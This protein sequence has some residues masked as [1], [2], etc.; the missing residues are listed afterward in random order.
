MKNSNILDSINWETLR[1]EGL[2]HL[3]AM[4]GHL[5]TDYD[6]HDPGVTIFEILCYAIADLHSRLSQDTI[7]LL[8][9]N[10]KEKQFFSPREILTMN[11]VTMNDYR[12]LL[13]DIPGVK[14]AWLFPAID[15]DPTLYYDKDNN[16][17]LYD[18]ASGS[19]RI[20]LKG[21]Y[22]VY[23]EKDGDY[24]EKDETTNEYH[25]LD[26]IE[27]KR[28]VEAKLH[29]YRNLGEE[30]AEINIMA[31]ET[32][33][34]FSD[35][36]IAETADANEVIAKIYYDLKNFISPR[37][38]Q[39]SLKRMFQKGKSIEQIFNGPQLENGFID[40]DEL[41]S[42]EK[43]KELHTSD[44]IRIIMSHPEVRD[45]RNLFIANVPNPDMNDKK[46]W[47]L[48]VDDTKALVMEPFNSVRIRLFKKEAM[49]PVITT[50]VNNKVMEL[51]EQSKWE[52]FDD[53]AVD[54][55]ETLGEASDVT[56]YKPLTYQFP[57]TYGVGETGLSSA[58]T[59]KRRA[60]AQQLKAYLLFFDQIL[61]NYLR[62]LDSFKQIFAFRQSPLFYPIQVEFSEK[63]NSIL[64]QY[65][66]V[67][68]P[69]AVDAFI[70]IGGVNQDLSQAIWT[71][72][73]TEGLIDANGNVLNLLTGKTEDFITSIIETAVIN[74]IGGVDRVYPGLFTGIS[75]INDALSNEIWTHLR[76]M[77]FINNNGEILPAYCPD[78]D[79]FNLEMFS[80]NN[81]KTY[82]SQLPP[83]EI[84][85]AEFPEITINYQYLEGDPDDG[86][87]SGEKT[88]QREN[89][90]L[91]HL[92]AQ[93]NEK[94]ADY[95]LFGFKNSSYL[96]AKAGFLRNYPELSRNRNRACNILA[97]IPNGQI[98]QY[99]DGLKDLIAAKLGMAISNTDPESKTEYNNFFIV[100]H[101]LFR[102]EGS[103][104][105]NFICSEKVIESYQPDPYSYRLTFVFSKNVGRFSNSKFK[106]LV[107]TTIENETPAHISYAILELDSIKMKLFT[108]T[109]RDFLRELKECKTSN[110]VRNN[111][112]RNKLIEF[113][114]I[115]RVKLP[116][117]HL[118]AH[119]M[120]GNGTDPENE[121]VVTFWKD[122]SRNDHDVMLETGDSLL[123]SDD[124][125]PKYIKT[126]TGNSPFVRFS[127]GIRL[128]AANL[129]IR[130]D[131]SMIVVYKA[132]AN[133]GH[134]D[135]YFK[136]LT[137][138][139]SAKDNYI[140]AVRGDGAVTGC[141]HWT[142]D[143]IIPASR[144]KNGDYLLTGGSDSN[145][146][147]VA[148]P[149]E[150]SINGTTAFVAEA[151]ASGEAANGIKVTVTDASDHI[152]YHFD[153]LVAG[154]EI[155]RYENLSMSRRDIN[156]NGDKYIGTQN[157]SNISI[158][159]ILT[160]YN[161]LLNLES[162]TGA[163]HIAIL[164]REKATGEFKIS[165]DGVLQTSQQLPNSNLPFSQSSLFIGPANDNGI[166]DLGEVIILDSVLNGNQKQK[167]EEYLSEKWNIPLSAVN[168]ISKPVL[169]LDASASRSVICNEKTKQIIM[170][171]DLSPAGMD[172]APQTVGE[173]PEYHMEGIG[174]LPAVYFGNPSIARGCE[175]I[176]PNLDDNKLFAGD[177]T[178]AI[179]YQ[180]DDSSVKG[181][182]RLLDGTATEA[183]P[184]K[185]SCSIGVDTYNHLIVR[186]GSETVKLAA[187]LNDP[188]I[189]IITGEVHHIQLKVSL[190]LDGKVSVAGEFSDAQVFKNCPN[191][192]AIGRSRNGENSFAGQ[193][194]QIIIYNQALTVWNR[195][196]LENYLSQ[197]WA[198]DISG[199]DRIDIPVLHLD[200]SRRATVMDDDNLKVSQWLDLSCFGNHANQNSFSRRPKFSANG[201]N[202]LGSIQL[203]QTATDGTDFYEDSLTI[204]RIIQ[205]DFTI[206]V[207]F[208]PDFGY[209]SGEGSG[210]ITEV[211]EET[212]WTKGVAILD[213]DCSGVYNDFGLS[214]GK[215]NSKMIVM[216]GIG[217]RLTMD[218]TIKTGELEFNKPHFVT[219]TRC[220][221]TGEVKLY[222]DGMLHAEAD[223][224][225]NVILNDSRSIKI[226]AFNSEGSP[227]HGFIGEVIIFDTMLTDKKRQ[228]IE[229]YLSAKWG[230]PFV[231]LPIDTT[232]LGLHLDAAN[233]ESIVKEPNNAVTRWIFTDTV[234]DIAATQD[235]SANRP[236][237]VEESFNGMPGVRF[238]N[239]FMI[240]EPDI[241][242]YD[243]LT[244]ALIFNPLS[245]G[246]IYPGWQYGAGLID[247]DTGGMAQNFGIAVNRNKELMMRIGTHQIPSP[248]TLNHPHIVVITREKQNG[249][250][251][252]R[253]Y[254]DG[255]SAARKT[256]SGNQSLNDTLELTI[257]AI[258]MQPGQKVSKGYFHGDIS[259]LI[260]FNRVLTIAERQILEKHLAMKWRIDTSG[261]NEISKPVLHL[262]ASLIGTI[263][264]T[265]SD[266]KISQ[267]LDVNRHYNNAVQAEQAQRP[268]YVT[269]PEEYN[270]L[271]VI[272]FDSKQHQCLTLKPVVKDDFTVI[273]VYKAADSNET[274][275]YMPVARDSFA[276]L[277]GNNTDQSEAVWLHLKN[278]GY[279]DGEGNVLATFAPGKTGFTLN[280]DTAV[281]NP[282][283]GKLESQ[284]SSIL[285]GYYDSHTT[286]ETDTFAEIGGLNQTLSET[287]RTRLLEKG[288]INERGAV[289]KAFT[290]NTESFIIPV[291]KKAIINEITRILV[292]PVSTSLFT[293]ISGINGVLSNEI[294]NNLKNKGYIDDVGRVL[295][296]FT[297]DTA[298]FT[299][300]LDPSI[301]GVIQ[302]EFIDKISSIVSMYY[303]SYTP[304]PN[305]AFTVIEGVSQAL[306]ETIKANMLEQGYIDILGYILKD[307]TDVPEAFF[308]PIIEAAIIN[309]II[310]V[311]R[312][313]RDSFTGVYGVNNTLSSAI[314]GELNNLGYFDDA[315]KVSPEITPDGDDFTLGLDITNPIQGKI[316]NRIGSILSGC[317]DSEIT[318]PVDAFTVIDGFNQ[319]LSQTVLAN[320]KE[321]GFITGNGDVRKT[322]TQNTEDFIIPIIET[323]II[324]IILAE[325]WVAGAGLF[326]GN[327]AGVREDM[328]KRD[329]G[330][331]IGRTGTFIVGIGVPGENDS[332]IEM[333]APFEAVHIGV[334]TRKKDTGMV[335]LF[336][337][338][339]AS[340]PVRMARNVI[341]KDSDRF[342]IGAVNTAGNYFKGDIAE[343]IVL[344][345]VLEPD[346][347]TAIQR[348]L[349]RKWG[350]PGIGE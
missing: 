218:H 79:G 173:G 47:A 204:S 240:V 161:E 91:N 187:T 159:D 31:Q 278:K 115:G 178:I 330:I 76:N 89:R 273:I 346:E 216:G 206:M 155:V 122:L 220:K 20:A 85:Q 34:V 198:I 287:I 229:K 219:F 78:Q 130:E 97:P 143:N 320:L 348:F 311:N 45:V 179:V 202:G 205:N 255:L 69:V 121:A 87:P 106:E 167:L 93:F 337:D 1:E 193:I 153:L 325:N 148:I 16:A 303:D 90:I 141:I 248:I 232:D 59:A 289:L 259:E 310:G 118:D 43:R 297:P 291:I 114:G 197:K 119:N 290:K 180:A 343:I 101:I 82:F 138:G 4:T 254:V 191:D 23:I 251:T 182:G 222:A 144:P 36:E 151:L 166:C 165:L 267:W 142:A 110:L 253:M 71:S 63:I 158:K 199:V 73:R 235:N 162:T 134:E 28:R 84:W 21:L 280:L 336:I 262:D 105:L 270:G 131:F 272:R 312:I 50:K 18:Y 239:S 57:S 14:N 264:K 188:H 241:N 103:L 308:N 98:F 72:L 225:D 329:F 81:I 174:G 13:I 305:D 210:I 230:I 133:P 275:A 263:V 67:Q 22:R 224:R 152:E 48:V 32:I 100:D 132:T 245:T 168:S 276:S 238:N 318:V 25:T 102:P 246:N 175:L 120:D 302:E 160:K 176:I 74:A 157:F 208:Q 12:K 39:Y 304:I 298:G 231:T 170:W 56:A 242:G 140:L 185:T 33:S 344:N 7:N 349:A 38:K 319:E 301:M 292:T 5:W 42:G 288:F 274:S 324:N 338:N 49:S 256:F 147:N 37:V 177:F 234:R 111:P 284:I 2:K 146:A 214:F 328:Y 108:D 233:F 306:S 26:D 313:S 41:G 35:I 223:L 186:G 68:Q 327:C 95:A 321:L 295:P 215:S 217:D 333:A 250:E 169:Q 277:T 88:F 128:K 96:N 293:G 150:D 340:E 314:W 99:T 332:K 285:S 317:V 269:T 236:Y 283:Q 129:P 9:D 77:R 44:L 19:Q 117:L 15:A 261:I 145:K 294:W 184:G 83:A 3:Q 61:V 181:E 24:T 94:F 268:L 347:I 307:F 55:E 149:L 309:M 51:Q 17:L 315:G 112:Y 172:A 46:E 196:R 195:Q 211:L 286:V 345:E 53:P 6:I 281:C 279:I 339:E 221:A 139:D 52:I 107:Y 257:G 192:L 92:L 316:E 183:G 296:A 163:S 125:K 64:S 70:S 66:V 207:A 203:T 40:D 331:L 104:P 265:E 190:Y 116:I 249:T 109:Y 124:S 228:S 266:N 260:L 300:D 326:D 10:T 164:T 271:G 86:T 75:G 212:N 127:G 209:Y 65:K 201:I 189:A 213:A 243:N 341:L 137:G 335:R 350:I 322:F 8:A 299:L 30:F 123:V 29:A 237:Y 226:G 171:N 194:A 80:T 334:L 323:A 227:F 113:L 156:G 258:R 60:Q 62:Q 58:V 135:E 252:V 136:M 27:L 54:L 11:P 154:D 244:I 342:T 126:K 200:A 282:I 247:N